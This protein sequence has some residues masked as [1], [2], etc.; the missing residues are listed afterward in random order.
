MEKENAYRYVEKYGLYW[1]DDAH[2]VNIELY[3]IRHG[4]QWVKKDGKTAGK[5]LLFHYAEAIKLIWPHIVQHRWFTFFLEHWLAYKFIGVMGPRNSGKSMCAA[6][7]H[8]TDYYAFPD[9]TTTMVCSTTKERLED[10]VWGDIKKYHTQAKNNCRWLPGVL[11]ESKQRL[12]TD[13][14]TDPEDARDFRNGFIGIPC[15][16]GNSVV[17]IGDFQGIKNKR[18]RLLGDELAALPK[19]F[20]DATAT[21][22]IQADIKVTG[23]GNPAQTTDPLGILCE[24]HVTL[25]GWEGGIDQTPKTKS[26]K[27]RFEGGICIQ[28]PGSDSPNMDVPEGDPV[29][30]PFLIGRQ[31]MQEDLGIWGKDDWHYTMFNEGRMPRGQGSRRVITRQLCLKHRA[32]EDPL[33]KNSNRTRITALDAAYRAVGGDRCVFME[34]DFGEEAEVDAGIPAASAIISQALPDSRADM[35][36]ALIDVMIIP[37][38][39]SDFESPEDQIAM[40]VKQEHERRGIPPENHFFDAGMRTSLVSAY[41]RLW[42]PAVNPIDFG[43]KPTERQVSTD[44]EV[45]CSDYYSK[46]VTELWW[47]VRLVIESEQF[48]GLTEDVMSEGCQ[49][50]WKMVAGNKIEV[51]T[52]E[53][54]K[55]K[56]GRSPDLFDTLVTAVEGARRMGFK[57][58]RIISKEAA[59]ENSQWKQEAREKSRAWVKSGQLSYR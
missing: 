16:K 52:K 14:R 15:K 32:M 26:W 7:F 25:G 23:M 35:I 48:R 36:M 18:I 59:V 22:D 50:E 3:M 54:M 20:I 4:G 31:Q 2:P 53:E 42:S 40:F 58:K 38:V 24:P 1:P 44:I 43:G 55:L 29:P 57:I 28:F 46:F 33:W 34:L 6:V 51:E 12:I 19:T 17:A 30:Y 21:L 39:A 9:C 49:R 10:R 45:A 37:I 11:I 41:S 5:G 27:T 56:T 13:I 8:L 47:S